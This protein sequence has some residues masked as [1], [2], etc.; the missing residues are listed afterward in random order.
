M[1]WD[2]KTRM[3]HQL[4]LQHP[5]VTTFSAIPSSSSNFGL[6]RHN[7]PL[8]M[9]WM[10]NKRVDS[11]VV[12]QMRSIV[13]SSRGWESTSATGEWLRAILALELAR[14]SVVTLR[15]ISCAWRRSRWALTTMVAR[16]ALIY[17]VMVPVISKCTSS[18]SSSQISIH[19]D[20]IA[21][22]G[23]WPVLPRSFKRALQHL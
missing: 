9:L 11:M 8:I 15:N 20:H 10:T 1:L 16:L 6:A 4:S 3:Y 7:L 22:I 18:S 12:G 13:S 21:A 17:L 2:K 23:R 5:S 19:R 14:R